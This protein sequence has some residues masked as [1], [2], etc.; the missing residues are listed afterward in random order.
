MQH[1]DGGDTDN[2]K[3]WLKQG[4]TDPAAVEAYYDEW[5]ETYDT[6]L[7]D[8]DYRAPADAA[9]LLCEHMKPGDRLLD[10]G[11]GTGLFAEAVA[12]RVDCPM[13]G[14]DISAASLEVAAKGGRYDRLH[15]HD[16]QQTPLPLGGDSFDAAACVGVLTYIEEPTELLADL[17]RVVRPGGHILFT[18]RE[19]RWTEKHFDALVAEFTKRGLWSPLSITEPKLYLPDNEDFSDSIRVVHVL[20]CVR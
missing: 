20:C 16:L 8:W 9:A 14:I 18:Q 12:D 17:C 10:V 4:T 13:E 11:C 6:T 5:A 3:G 7:K 15:R 19:D 2:E 1:D